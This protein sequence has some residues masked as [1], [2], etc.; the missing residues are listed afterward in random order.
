PFSPV[1]AAI[2]GYAARPS[3]ATNINMLLMHRLHNNILL[4]EPSTLSL[5]R[6]MGGNYN[7]SHLKKTT[8]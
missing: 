8:R 7:A 1:T 2:A 6:P 3:T 5:Q 4:N